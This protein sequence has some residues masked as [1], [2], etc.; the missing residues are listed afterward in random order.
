MDFKN[1]TDLYTYLKSQNLPDG[2]GKEFERI[3]IHFL[4]TDNT[5]RY[6]LKD[7]ISWN[8]WN[9]RKHVIKTG[10]IGIDLVAE[11]IHG[12][13]WAIQCKFYEAQNSITLQKISTFIATSNIKFIINGVE[14]SFD[15]MI[16]VTTSYILQP[17]A[18]KVLDQQGNANILNRSYLENANINWNAIYEGEFGDHAIG[19]IRTPREHQIEAIDKTQSYF[20]SKDRGKLIMACGTGKTFTALKIAEQHSF[21]CFL[22]PSIALLGQT[23]REWTNYTSKSII[24]ILVCSDNKVGKAD[25]IE[26]NKTDHQ[27]ENNDTSVDLALP[28]TTNPEIIVH[29]I[30]KARQQIAENRLIVCFSTYQSIDRVMEAQ[31]LLEKN[32]G[33]GSFDLIICDEAHRTAGYHQRDEEGSLFVK[34][35]HR[36]NIKGEKR[37]YMT[38]TPKI[39]EENIKTKDAMVTYSMDDRSDTNM[40]G[41]EIYR[42][43][44]GDAIKENLLA[45][46]QVLI[47]QL[48]QDR[49]NE[50]LQSMDYRS[51]L[52]SQEA[53]GLLNLERKYE[54]NLALKLMGSIQLLGKIIDDQDQVLLENDTQP[55]KNAVA[56]CNRIK[57]SEKIRNTYNH[58]QKIG[59]LND[60]GGALK[61]ISADHVDGKEP[62]LSRL[63][64]LNWLKDTQENTCKILSN[65]K[66]L[67]EGVDVPTLDAILFLT[68]KSSQI[69]I[70]QSVG[71]VMRQADNK[72]RG[73]ILI[74]ILWNQ[75]TS[76]ESQL[77]KSEEFGIIWQVLNALRSHDENF[78]IE[79]NQIRSDRLIEP[80]EDETQKLKKTVVIE[81][82][83]I[84]ADEQF[85]E[86]HQK[87]KN[88]LG[89]IAVQT[90]G[91]I[92]IQ[93]SETPNDHYPNTNFPIEI[94]NEEIKRPQPKPPRINVVHSPNSHLTADEDLKRK[95]A[96]IEPSKLSKILLGKIVEKC[97]N[98]AYWTDWTKSVQQVQQ[99]EID[100]LI[101]QIDN[102]Y[103]VHQV[104]E[105]FVQSLQ[106]LNDD[107]NE[108]TIQK[109]AIKILADHIILKPIF[110]H[111]FPTYDIETNHSI[112]EGLENVLEQLQDWGHTDYTEQEQKELKG[113]Y[114]KIENQ[115]KGVKTLGGKQV[116]IKEF[117]GGYFQFSDQQRTKR[118]GIVYTPIGIIDFMNQSVDDL[119]QQY[120]GKQMT[121]KGVHVLDPFTGTGTYITRL[122]ESEDLIKKQDVVR[123]YERELSAVELQLLAYYIADVNI[124]TAYYYRMN[125]H[126][127]F[128]GII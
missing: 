18:K 57:D 82:R 9:H 101:H 38:A 120:F 63:N 89:L 108:E 32:D 59:L 124:E 96:G 7:V 24:P 119:L 113:V 97:G 50:Q 123:K 25:T 46:Y 31:Q 56:F 45:D 26:R 102:N 90:N 48:D 14:K 77:K 110:K 23:L 49:M 5:Y 22:V 58:F 83:N 107:A 52:S 103:A 116:I 105:E 72:K 74:P 33:Q 87:L 43:N 8:E 99:K 88:K 117:Y 76:P 20:Q 19:E 62:S 4:K 122:L 93:S 80:S 94:T 36:S 115:I 66:C 40:F 126:K 111:L 75:D 6:L 112:S 64:K 86:Y 81:L 3:I 92:E 44:F 70:V 42:L 2:G 30:Q 125:E 91:G 118:D 100:H 39:Y 41:D 78:D 60:M 10:D 17:N 21:V 106:V 54:R 12:E 98:R 127:R 27:E 65:A 37:L 67:T 61:E 34:V 1:F 11:A 35:H 104:F 73:Y 53:Q 28:A 128:H 121:E 109:E 29:R 51:Q 71:R 47:M 68:K 13:F 79:I 69:D 15:K 16:L 95:I 84:Q 114:E 85:Q 55:M